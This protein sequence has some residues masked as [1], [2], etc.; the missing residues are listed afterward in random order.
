MFLL[1]AGIASLLPVVFGQDV[2]TQPEAYSA[3]AV[4][5]GGRSISF[6]FRITDYTRDEDM[7]KFA[8]LLKEKGPDA[9]PNALEKEDQ[10]RINPVGS[11]GSQLAVARKRQEGST[12][13]ITVVTARNMPFIEL[14]RN[15]R[16]TDYPFGFL[17]VRLNAKGEGTGQIMA[18][19]KIRFDKK[20]GHYEIESYGNQ[21][22]KAVNVRPLK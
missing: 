19:A 7:Q 17:Q 2:K 12:T 15:N 5:T 20:K 6:D 3:V 9:L 21:Y 11:V 13:I 1:G 22:I 8:D 16:S 18:A 14:Y 4:G 10:G